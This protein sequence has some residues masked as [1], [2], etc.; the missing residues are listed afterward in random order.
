MKIWGVRRGFLITVAVLILLPFAV[1]L[2]ISMGIPPLR[3]MRVVEPR[4]SVQPYWHYFGFPSTNA[5]PR[6]VASIK[7]TFTLSCSIEPALF[8]VRNGRAQ[9][10]SSFVVGRSPNRGLPV[11]WSPL[12]LTLA[13][14][15]IETNNIVLTSLGC[16]GMERAQGAPGCVASDIPNLYS[17]LL[18]GRIRRKHEYLVYVE[19]N[20]TFSAER[21]WAPK[22][23]AK[24]NT[25]GDFIMVSI[26]V[27]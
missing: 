19:G 26:Y 15:D 9:Y 17:S 24:N 7:G 2:V 21:E 18:T 8:T 1:C 27:H 6:H 16:A 12:E 20:H 10:W 22:D 25:T 23:F 11:H 3:S 13:L 14:G 5:T 4:L